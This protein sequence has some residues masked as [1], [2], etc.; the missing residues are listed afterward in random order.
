V[1]YTIVKR[2][3]LLEADLVIGNIMVNPLLGLEVVLREVSFFP[4]PINSLDPSL[5]SLYSISRTLVDCTLVS[6]P[7]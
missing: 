3:Y 5:S 6:I 2:F 7:S 4:K 1:L